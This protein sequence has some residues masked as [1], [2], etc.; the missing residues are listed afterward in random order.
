M[1]RT[2]GGRPAGA[3]RGGAGKGGGRAG[4]AC[5]GRCWRPTRRARL[6]LR[7]A[8]DGPALQLAAA[9][10]RPV[11]PLSR[12]AHDLIFDDRTQS[13]CA[14]GWWLRDAHPFWRRWVKLFGPAHCRD[15]FRYWEARQATA[16]RA[17]P[18]LLP[19]RPLRP[20]DPAA[21]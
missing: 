9:L 3:S 13:L 1:E 16:R 4:T 21:R 12:L 19:P 5:A 17:V 11:E 10:I 15:S 14:R 6:R 2:G 7:L 8:A 20:G 18:R